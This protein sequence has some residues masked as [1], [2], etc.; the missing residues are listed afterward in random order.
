MPTTYP[1]QNQ[2]FFSPF[3]YITGTL[4]KAHNHNEQ[5]YHQNQWPGKHL[6]SSFKTINSEMSQMFQ[7]P[8]QTMANP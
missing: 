7:P 6:K 4:N 3:K 1:G 5:T 2:S 8:F